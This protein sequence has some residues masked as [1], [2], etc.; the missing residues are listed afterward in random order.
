MKNCQDKFDGKI[1]IER[2][3]GFFINA[4]RSV[5]LDRDKG[6]E[7]FVGQLRH[8]LGQVVDGL[9]FFAR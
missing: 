2:H 4:N 5:S 6:A 7:L 1:A 9:P 3:A 8:R